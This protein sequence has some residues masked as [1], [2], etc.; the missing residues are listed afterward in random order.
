[1][2]IG[3]IPGESPDDLV[4]R[5]ERRMIPTGQSMWEQREYNQIVWTYS[6]MHGPRYADYVTFNNYTMGLLK[7]YINHQLCTIEQFDEVLN[8]IGCKE[9][10]EQIYSELIRRGL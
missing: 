5:I 10:R 8:A 7:C 2:S 4:L 9:T 6:T 3:T 1:M